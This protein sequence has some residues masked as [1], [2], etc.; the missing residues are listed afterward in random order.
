MLYI[1]RE[2]NSNNNN[3]YFYYKTSY[4]NK[5]QNHQQYHHHHHH[6]HH[7]QQ[8][9]PQPQQITVQYLPI[10]LEIKLYHVNVHL[11]SRHLER[12]VS[13]GVF[14]RTTALEGIHA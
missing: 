9:Q 2:D 5:K 6:H 13:S 10:D 3:Y 12:V 14:S 7:Q 11:V 1:T 8:Q 4:N